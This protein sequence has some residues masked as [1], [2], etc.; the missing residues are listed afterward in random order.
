MSLLHFIYR[1][2]L[3]NVYFGILLMA[4]IAVY[5]AI[6]SGMP[7]VR[8]YFEMDEIAFFNTKFFGA[9][10]AIFA[11]N[12]VVVTVT[13]IPLTP[14]RYGVWMVHLGI[15]LL[16][17]SMASY[18]WQKYEGLA[19]VPMKGGTNVFY[20]RFERAMYARVNVTSTQGPLG[21]TSLPMRMSTLPRF[22]EY[23]QTLGN[24]SRLDRPELRSLSPE[25]RDIVPG[26]FETRSAPLHEMIGAQNPVKL[27]VI[28]F[29]PY[30]VVKRWDVAKP[31]QEVPAADRRVAIAIRDTAEREPSAIWLVPDGPVTDY[32]LIIGQIEIEHRTVP[33]R[34]DAKMLAASL[35]RLHRVS[36]RLGDFNSEFFVE[37]GRSYDLGETGYRLRIEGF[38]RDWVT[39]DGE[40][41]VKALSM[42]VERS[43]P[44]AGQ[45][46][47]FRRMVLNE[48]PV[49]TDF[50]LDEPGAGPMGKRQTSPLDPDLNISYRFADPVDLSPTRTTNRTILL[51]NGQDGSVIRLVSDILQ[52]AE[53]V[54]YGA[55]KSA[56]APRF[57]A[58]AAAG[59][60]Q[61]DRVQRSEFEFNRIENVVR[62]ERAVVVP[63]AQ[64]DSEEGRAGRFQ[65][66]KV[67]VTSGQWGTDVYVPYSPFAA[68]QAWPNSP[69]QVPDAAI[70]FNLQ[71]S[72]TRLRLP[73]R[74]QLDKFEAT[75][76]A[77]GNVSRASLMRDFKS[78]LTFSDLSLR[79]EPIQATTSLNS[80]AFYSRSLV[81]WLPGE[82]WIFYQAQ[83]DPVAQSF[84]ILGV[85]NRPAVRTMAFS[86]ILIA[87][88]VLYAFYVKPVIVNRMKT[89]AIADAQARRGE[90]PDHQSNGTSNHRTPSHGRAIAR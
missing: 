63:A 78:Y 38:W 90:L 80:P 29:Y 32:R 68:E 45:P 55:T 67:R 28:G 37:P 53:V 61:S 14:P 51:T 48:K 76:F 31:G 16:I 84:T 70:G 22:G 6:G 1:N 26:T 25:L 44:P 86:C 58:S 15:I 72:N 82:S 30:A 2:T 20:D 65:V 77:G 24:D 46:E 81:S 54:E 12:M 42:L 56:V 60:M 73:V 10:L 47:L 21:R 85:A 27:D 7:S 69:I 35:G 33:T 88:G 75:P 11:V 23:S 5:I 17:L 8:E 41:D 52:P 62:N 36:V 66:V 50:R 9:L 89:K 79:G 40:K 64:R 71:L 87:I 18:F 74:V 57:V 19:F 49:Q 43:N 59:P 34:E 3:R 13:R 83:W 4:M 39:I